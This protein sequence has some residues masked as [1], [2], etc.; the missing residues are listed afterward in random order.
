MSLF[1]R[2]ASYTV[3]DAGEHEVFLWDAGELIRHA[4]FATWRGAYR[5][6]LR[7]VLHGQTGGRT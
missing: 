1:V 7:W 6:G 2:R 4:R 5:V 3:S